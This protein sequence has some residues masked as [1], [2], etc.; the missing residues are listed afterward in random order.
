MKKTG[1]ITVICAV[2]LL[3]AA[4]PAFSQSTDL[5]A[6]RKNVDAFSDKFSKSL[7][8]N[9]TMG[10][11]WS[12]AYIGQL[13]S[14]PPH[15]GI[16]FNLGFT[17]VDIGSLGD[18]MGALGAG[19]KISDLPDVGGLPLPGYTI[20]A[21]IGGLFLPFDIGFKIGYLSPGALESMLGVG[22]NYL[23]VGA[24]IRY[25]LIN[26]KVLP[27]KLSLGLGYNYLEGGLST[28]V[29]SAQTF[30]FNDGGTPHT[31]EL[32]APRLGFNWSS[33][34]LELKAQVSFP[35]LIITP[36]AGVGL[37]VA[38]TTSGYS[39]TSQLTVDG[40]SFDPYASTLKSYGLD[41]LTS[42]GFESMNDVTSF[43]MRIFGGISF[44]ITVI[45]LDFTGMYNFFDNNWG[46]TFGT[47]FQM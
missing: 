8:F 24:D 31:L 3:L 26:V 32:T 36:Y 2:I 1:K 34:V 22:V 45:R 40:G 14:V 27:I 38:W 15:F 41:G 47:R 35:L 33:K 11:N 44:N 28:N 4:A 12:D 25:S 23:L 19:S 5:S 43:N 30:D 46:I 42:N 17:T 9:A 37:S 16:G 20:D 10:L 39:V 7:P 18:L 13:F 21:R 6:L 29:G